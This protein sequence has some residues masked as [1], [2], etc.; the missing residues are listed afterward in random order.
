MAARS[1]L[2]Q[3]LALDDP[4][5][6]DP[7]APDRAVGKAYVYRTSDGWEVSGYYRRDDRDTWHPFLMSLDEVHSVV[8][9]KVRDSEFAARGRTDVRLEVLE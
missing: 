2:Q 4:E 1:Q 7:L 3:M 5:L 8:R 6:V 9:L